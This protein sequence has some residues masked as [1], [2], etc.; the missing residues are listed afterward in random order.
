MIAS[1][2]ARR[3]VAARTSRG[4][5]A[6]SDAATARPTAASRPM[7]TIRPAGPRLASR[8]PGSGL[9]AGV[10]W[11]VMPSGNS[12]AFWKNAAGL[13]RAGAVAA[14]RAT[15]VTADTTANQ[16]AS[17]MPSRE[18]S[19]AASTGSTGQAVAFIAHATPMTRPAV[20]GR[21]GRMSRA[22]ARQSNPSTGGSVMPTAS[23]SAHSGEASASMEYLATD[24]R[25]P[26]HRDAPC[27]VPR[28]SEATSSTA[29]ATASHGLVS[30]ARPG[31]PAALGSPKTAM[32][33]RYG[34]YDIQP[35][36]CPAGRYGLPWRSSR[37]ADL[38]TTVTSAVIGARR[39]SQAS[40]ATTA[41]ARPGRSAATESGQRHVR[42]A[43]RA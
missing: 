7:A 25:Q 10:A 14:A 11:R 28:H 8:C 29:V 26:A 40:G 27:G 43:D 24:L 23:G 4:G 16:I 30:P 15:A 22:S 42:T 31:S 39:A 6:T 1:P 32:T 34:L 36:S 18:A 9:A 12:T 13:A 37:L 33:G 41:P 2:M 5:R 38:V 20:T 21:D 17:R 35:T 19:M 3:Q